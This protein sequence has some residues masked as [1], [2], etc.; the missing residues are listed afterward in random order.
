MTKNIVFYQAHGD[1]YH[2]IIILCLYQG[3]YITEL[4]W[5]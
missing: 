1:L 5:K 4:P 2:R 3:I